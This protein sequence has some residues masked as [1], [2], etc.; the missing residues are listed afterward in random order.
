MSQS[1]ENRANIT[2]N[3]ETSANIRSAV[4]ENKALVYLSRSLIEENRHMILSNYSAAFMGNRQLANQNT[5]DITANT[6][7]ILNR[8][9]PENDV[10]RNYV[11]AA[12]NSSS[13]KALQHRSQL[14]TAVLDI[15]EKMAAINSDLI[16]LNKAIML[17]NEEIVNYNAAG[18]AANASLLDGNMSPSGATP[19]K[20][21]E[22]IATNKGML[23]P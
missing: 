15:S 22:I 5:D 16:A 4:S 19:E 11:D 9:E 6:N 2:A 14:N 18:I 7:I 20:N 12:L 8:F 21:A 23:G 10:Q 17:A 3:Q 13:L 1:S